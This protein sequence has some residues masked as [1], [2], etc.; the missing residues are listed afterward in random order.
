MK[1]IRKAVKLKA[2]VNQVVAAVVKIVISKKTLY[3]K[4]IQNP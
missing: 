1:K 2:V 3:H 4:I